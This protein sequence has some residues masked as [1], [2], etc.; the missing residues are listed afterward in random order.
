M[1]VPTWVSAKP[2]TPFPTA[3][4]G[5]LQPTAGDNWCLGTSGVPLGSVLAPGLFYTFLEH[6]NEGTESITDR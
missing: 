2:L 3:S 4:P 5:E 1:D 6:L